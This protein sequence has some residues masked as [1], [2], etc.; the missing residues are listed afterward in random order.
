MR[1]VIIDD[2]PDAISVLEQLLTGVEGVTVSGTATSANEGI[3]LIQAQ[4]PELVFLDIEMPQKS[5]FD[6]LRAFPNPAFRVIFATAFD[7]YTIQA[8]RHS[9]LDYLIKPVDA[10]ELTAAVSRAQGFQHAPDNRFSE[11]HK[12]VQDHNPID[13]IIIPSKMGFKVLLLDQICSIEAV[14][15]N[16]AF[17]TLLN[18]KRQLCTKPLNYYE[19]LL[20]GTF[21]IRIHRSCIVNLKQ[22]SNYD[23][24]TGS[25]SL[26]NQLQCLVATR[27]QA[28]FRRKMRELE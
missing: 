1:T 2:E 5:G 4:K 10:R 22:V 9:A 16:Y 17:F 20:K 6:L 25:V 28:A 15:G 11:L 27:R 19:S 24:N 8:I 23:S 14:R 13:R 7:Q 12:M 18:G 21:F 26:Y 3:E